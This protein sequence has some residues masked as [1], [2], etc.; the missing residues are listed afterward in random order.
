LETDLIDV[1]LSVINQILTE[2]TVKWSSDTSI[3]VVMAS[4]GYPGN[5]NVGYK[6]SGHEQLN[7]NHLVFHSGTKSQVSKESKEHI[8]VTA[9]GRVLTL[10]SLG[11]NLKE[12]RDLVYQG[13]DKVA[14][15]DS[16]YRIDIGQS[17]QANQ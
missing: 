13:I 2:N 17:N 15:T 7:D 3:G 14:F 1:I 11:K 6:I 5:F 8:L 12:A 4:K 9:G 16:F 10:V